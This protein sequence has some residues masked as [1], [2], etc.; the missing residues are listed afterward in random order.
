M[1][2]NPLKAVGAARVA[3]RVFAK[4]SQKTRQA[5]AKKYRLDARTLD[6]IELAGRANGW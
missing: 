5:I 2:P 4:T 6:L 3:R 1:T